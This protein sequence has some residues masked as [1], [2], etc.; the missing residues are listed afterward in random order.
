MRITSLIITACLLLFPGC[1]H[2]GT[3]EPPKPDEKDP[4]PLVDG[5]ETVPSILPV[6]C[7]QV[8][9]V[10]GNTPAGETLPNPNATLKR[11]NMAST[12]F[13]NMWD[14]GNGSV[15]SV[16]G[17]NFN[18]IDLLDHSGISICMGNGQEDSRAQ[19]GSHG[20]VGR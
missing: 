19:T 16:F 20:K 8:A 4:Y 6:E 12:D 11:F 9:R 10:I 18:D 13:G 15:F 2:G 14:A 3:T 1:K 7:T 17:D 5:G